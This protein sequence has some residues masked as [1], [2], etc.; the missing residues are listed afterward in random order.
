M[1]NYRA[2]RDAEYRTI[3]LL[4]EQGYHCTRAAGSKGLWDVIGIGSRDV[5]LAQ[6]KRAVRAPS[7]SVVDSLAEVPLP[8]NVRALLYYW[9]VGASTPIVTPVPSKWDERELRGLAIA[10]DAAATIREEADGSWRVP[11]QRTG[12]LYTVWPDVGQCTCPDNTMRRACCKH[13]RAIQHLTAL[14]KTNP[15][16]VERMNR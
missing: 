10:S 11:S 4:E 6:V 3:R 13:L 16:H 8:A 1:T 5:V 12:E 14:D 7:A 9:P 15:S 2:G